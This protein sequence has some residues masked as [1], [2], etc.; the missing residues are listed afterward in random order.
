MRN[1][2][3][4]MPGKKPEDAR[5]NAVKVIATQRGCHK[6]QKAGI[7]KTPAYLF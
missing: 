6:K 5:S 3:I 1:V 2:L 4:A 7:I